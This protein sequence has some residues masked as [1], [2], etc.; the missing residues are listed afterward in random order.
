MSIRHVHIIISALSVPPQYLRSCCQTSNFSGGVFPLPY[1][2]N[3]FNQ[4]FLVNG[5]AK[6]THDKR[7]MSVPIGQPQHCGKT[8]DS[9]TVAQHLPMQENR[10]W[11][12]GRWGNSAQSIF[13][14][15]EVDTKFSITVL[16]RGRHRKSRHYKYPPFWLSVWKL[17]WNVRFRL[18]C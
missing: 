17:G 6:I 4:H 11:H 10:E 3:I 13:L 5:I 9:Y 7:F 1:K 14:R 2:N 18:F 12:R 15:R 8:K 16:P